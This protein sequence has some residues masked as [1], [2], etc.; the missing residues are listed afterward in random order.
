[1]VAIDEEGET[2]VREDKVLSEEVDELKDLLGPPP[3]LQGQVDVGVVRLHYTTEQHRHNTWGR[4][5]EGV[6]GGGNVISA[7]K[8]NIIGQQE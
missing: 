7:R 1:M 3:R 8:S 2:H 5:E 6:G 4:K